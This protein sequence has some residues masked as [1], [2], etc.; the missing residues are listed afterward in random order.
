MPV[1]NT[2]RHNPHRRRSLAFANINPARQASDDHRSVIR[3]RFAGH[4]KVAGHLLGC[5][6]D[7]VRHVGSFLSHRGA[8]RDIC[9]LTLIK[10]A[11][12]V[13]PTPKPTTL[14]RPAHSF[15]LP[16]MKPVEAPD[17]LPKFFSNA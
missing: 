16:S 11:L 2:S 3:R 13:K 14:A 6:F 17:R 15:L 12:A 1:A 10:P 5:S 7:C 4:Y 8:A 9:Q